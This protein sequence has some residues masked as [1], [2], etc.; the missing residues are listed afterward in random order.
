MRHIKKGMRMLGIAE[1]FYKELG[2]SILVGV[3][4]RADRIIDG[5]AI[6]FPTVGGLDATEKILEIYDDLRRDDIDVIA[7]S[8]TVIS[9]YNV[10]DLNKVYEET[11]RPVISI[12]YEESEGLLTYFK[13]NFPDD[14]MVRWEIHS[15]NG[16]RIKV[17]LR[18][19]YEVFIRPIGIDVDYALKI[20][21]KFV[22][23][24]KKPEPIRIAQLIASRLSK[25][26][27]IYLSKVIK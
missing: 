12:T 23:E 21:N 3:V 25:K 18:T 15:R 8:G 22:V 27:L 20:L 1:S 24:G 2:K 11:G 16:Q 13:K 17:K 14:W 6:S 10:I 26:Y 19:G 4:E 5:F 9:W 7:I